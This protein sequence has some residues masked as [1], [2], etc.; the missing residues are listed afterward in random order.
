MDSY[1]TLVVVIHFFNEHRGSRIP[2]CDFCNASGTVDAIT[3]GT[4]VI[5]D[6]IQAS[7][8]WVVNVCESRK[9]VGVFY[10]MSVGVGGGSYLA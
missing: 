6:I 5:G 4:I 2:L 10:G 9:V 8:S 1:I 7:T 3:S